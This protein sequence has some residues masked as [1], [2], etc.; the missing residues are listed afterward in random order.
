[1][2]ES[3]WSQASCVSA[4]M[5]EAWT[6][7]GIGTRTG[8]SKRQTMTLQ[9]SSLVLRLSGQ[10]LI[11]ATCISCHGI[12]SLSLEMRDHNPLGELINQHPSF[13]RLALQIILQVFFLALCTSVLSLASDS[14][15][16]LTQPHL[17]TLCASPFSATY[18]QHSILTQLHD[19]L[20]L[21]IDPASWLCAASV[22]TKW[23][24]C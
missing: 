23:N 4:R 7:T 14:D 9:R 20:S 12:P 8:A 17:S 10:C 2:G 24:F 15:S 11:R 13:M 1:M 3:W 19:W 18:A 21:S 22:S 6:P 5:G 16:L